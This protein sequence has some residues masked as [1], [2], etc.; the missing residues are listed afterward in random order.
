MID[1][2]TFARNK[3]KD[4]V[5]NSVYFYDEAMEKERV[6]NNRVSSTM[7]EA[8]TKEEFVLYYQPKFD[9]Q[10][11]KTI[12]AEALVR[13][14]REG[15]LI[16]PNDFI[17]IFERNGFI[18]KLDYYVLTQVCRYIRKQD[19][20]NLPVI[21][22][23]LSGMTLQQPNV[24]GQ[25][26]Q[27]LKEEEVT[28]AQID[29]EVT[30]SAFVD[31]GE[32]FTEKLDRF[33]QLGFTISMDDFGA[34]ISSLNRLKEIPLDILKIDRAFIVGSLE[35]EKGGAIIENVIRMAKQIGLETVAEGIETQEQL[36][37]LRDQGCCVGQGYFYSRPL[38]EADF[39]AFYQTPL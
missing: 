13:W 14:V 2:A 8:L 6:V 38:P 34:G 39:T 19:N 11:K 15:T 16:P 18:E 10:K 5:G 33:R 29:L 32:E 27:I 36:D 22:V 17:P 26:I 20:P 9:L 12:G 24:V 7:H 1:N 21:S 35:N 4:K 23:N 37:Y 28:P 31:M 25:I 30:E 3:G